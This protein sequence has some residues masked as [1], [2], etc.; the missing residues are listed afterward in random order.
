NYTI[1]EIL[2]QISDLGNNDVPFSLL[3]VLKTLYGQVLKDQNHTVPMA[4]VVFVTDTTTPGSIDGAENYA[5]M[6]KNMGV[7]LTG[8][9]IGNKVSQNAVQNLFDNFVIWSNIDTCDLENCKPD[10]WGN[11][12]PGAYGCQGG[13]STT[14]GGTTTIAT[15]T[16]PPTT[17][18][19]SI[20][21]PSSMTTRSPPTPAFLC[22][23]HLPFAVDIST[24]LSS[25]QFTSMINMIIDPFLSIVYP[26]GIKP[27]R[28]VYYS[29]SGFSQ[30]APQ[31]VSDIEKGVQV[32]KQGSVN[33]GS[34]KA[35]L[36]TLSAIDVLSY[37]DSLPINTVIFTGTWLTG[38]EITDVQSL[39]NSFSGNGSTVTVVLMKG[40]IDLSNYNQITNLK[41]VN[42]DS[43]Q[44]YIISDL[45]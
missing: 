17:Q 38:P 9:L 35:A 25:D 11:L 26:P 15:S 45:E 8:L 29:N 27:A 19:T 16:G 31:N 21:N 1:D 7:K 6:I 5:T 14:S 40:G 20:T 10:N 3:N 36:T 13:S 23:A 34:L 32:L 43:N 12:A 30:R 44:D 33:K 22:N 28:W 37:S 39:V 42:W 4:A 24:A 2:G 41:I 18:T